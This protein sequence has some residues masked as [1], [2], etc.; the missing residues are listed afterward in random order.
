LLLSPP[1][2]AVAVGTFFTFSG[3]ETPGSDRWVEF[4]AFCVATAILPT[5]YVLALRRKGRISGVFIP[6][7]RERVRPL[8]ASAGSCLV[9]FLALTAVSAGS[10]IAMLQLWYGLFGLLAAAIAG[11]RHMSLHAAGAWGPVVCLGYCFGGYAGLFV[12]AALLVTW[13]RYALGTHCVAQ[14]VAGTLVGAT[15]ALTLFTVADL[16]NQLP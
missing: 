14:L 11:R 5:A 12:P 16:L 13:A 6:N 9:G 3:D 4:A 2:L 15:S 8:L 7:G 1:L 10:H